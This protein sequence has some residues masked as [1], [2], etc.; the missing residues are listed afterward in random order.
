MTN[1]FHINS[2]L[3]EPEIHIEYV[4][5]IV[6]QLRVLLPLDKGSSMHVVTKLYSEAGTALS[7]AN[8]RIEEWR[9]TGEY[10]TGFWNDRLMLEFQK[11]VSTLETCLTSF[12]T[13]WSWVG[14]EDR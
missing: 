3:D 5:S 8:D 6:N 14:K 7:V 12:R 13:K 11:Q 2:K 9:K 1:C 4:K 10:D